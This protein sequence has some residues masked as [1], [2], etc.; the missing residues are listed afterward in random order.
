MV[1]Y[2]LQNSTRYFNQ[3]SYELNQTKKGRLN[4]LL[5]GFGS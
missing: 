3:S 5:F 4:G 1:Q 2:L